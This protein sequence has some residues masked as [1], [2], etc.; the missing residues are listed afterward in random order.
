MVLGDS[1]TAISFPLMLA[2]HVGRAVWINRRL[3]AF[4]WKQVDRLQPDEVWWAPTER[5][6]L[7]DPGYHP[8]DFTA[9]SAMTAPL[10]HKS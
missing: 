6:L 4:D 5:L 7:C 3:C 10:G 1:F 9:G 8:I 2:Q